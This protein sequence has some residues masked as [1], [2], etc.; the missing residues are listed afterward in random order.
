MKQLKHIFIYFSFVCITKNDGS[1]LMSIYGGAF[2]DENFTLKHV[3]P[4]YLS[5]VRVNKQNLILFNIKN[6]ID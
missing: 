5:M 3:G 4:G 1:G 2:A 6:E